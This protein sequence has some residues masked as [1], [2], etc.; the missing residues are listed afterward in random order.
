MTRSAAV[1]AIF[2]DED[3]VPA[4]FRM[5][6]LHQTE[7][8]IDGALRHWDG[9]MAEVFSGMCVRT[10]AGVT[11]KRIG[12]YPMLTEHE[13]LEAL[14]AAVRA[15]DSGGGAWPTMPVAERIAHVEAFALRMVEKRHEVV[16]L[17]MWEIG[18][19]HADATRE[20]DRTVAYIR[21]TIDALKE[22]DRAG[23]RFTI[24][25][26][27][28]GQI[29]RAP[30]GVVL[31]M[32]PY[33]Y[34]LNETFTLLI[35]ALIMGN[36]TV[37]KPPRLG[38]LLYRPLLEAFRDA[39]PPGVVNTVYGRGSKVTPPLMASGKVDVLAFIGSSAAA[40]ALK[41]AHPKP[42]RLR[43]VLGLEAKNAAIVLPDAD[44]DLTVRECVLGTLSFNGQRCTAL[45]MLYVHRDIIDAFLDRFN[46]AIVALK[47]GMPWEEGVNL[48]PLPA[49]EEVQRHVDLV[50]DAVAH[51]ARVVNVGGGAVNETFFYPAV[52]YPVTAEMRLY[53]EEQFGPTIPVA[54]F[55]D[56]ETPIRYIVES[57]YGQQASIFG[58]DPDIIGRLIDPLV[59]Q[60]CRLN[61][62]SQCQRGPD[63][64]PFT[65]RKD[66][67]EGTLSVS[68]ALR[69][70]T[71]RTL[72]AAKANDLN[73][74]LITDIVR[75]RKSNFLSTDF[76]F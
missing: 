53:H 37:F 57:N 38:A 49:K 17:I 34:P 12:A 1:D 69:V 21:D 42:H 60:V 31:C 7:Y 27:I 35:P 9:P 55:D 16:S 48:T 51:G 13:A 45:K 36:T 66:S 22:L 24:Q 18:K 61:I 29:R 46:Q 3:K 33:N 72:V 75:E 63:T 15:Y 43:S 44:L 58:S 59:N 71:I 23:S 74:A 70:F 2:P 65:G 41:K 76:I 50:A 19:S 26:G 32:G 39:F 62:N 11:Q 10:A 73:K 68:D 67:A 6:P 40:D 14:D 25:E 52:V 8:L 20:F 4:A 30:L 28:I 54:A 47:I 56:I 5:E 64:F